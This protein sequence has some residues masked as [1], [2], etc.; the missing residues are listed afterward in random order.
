MAIAPMLEPRRGCGAAE[1]NG[2]I[3][4]VGGTNGSCSLKSIEIYNTQTNK[5]TSG[6][7]LNTPRANVAIAFIGI[8]TFWYLECF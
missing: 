3:Y 4:I 1:K 5:F 7:E 8:Y 2:L 6:P